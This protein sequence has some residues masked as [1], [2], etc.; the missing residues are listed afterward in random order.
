MFD[1]ETI[2][3]PRMNACSR[4]NFSVTAC[5]KYA[6]HII[7]NEYVQ[8]ITVKRNQE[9]GDGAKTGDGLYL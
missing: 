3:L 2:E 1:T 9:P 5:Y 6:T 4:E 7:W 8:R